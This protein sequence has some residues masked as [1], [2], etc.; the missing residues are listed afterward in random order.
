MSGFC[1]KSSWPSL[2]SRLLRVFAGSGVEFSR[3]E[4]C[5]TDVEDHLSV[6]ELEDPVDKPA[7][8][9]GT[10]VSVLYSM[11]LPFF[12]QRWLLSTDL[13]IGISV[14]SAE[15]SKR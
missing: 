12:D 11:L 8:K 13:L 2:R 15:L 3:I 10:Q 7:A 4:S 9:I 5:D 6:L 14:I 1:S